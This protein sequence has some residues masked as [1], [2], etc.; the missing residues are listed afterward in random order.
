MK[1]SITKEN[2][3]WLM[4]VHQIP[5][6]PTSRR[7]RTWRRLQDIGAIA[8][9]NSVY[10][11]PDTKETFEDFQWLKQEIIST[12]GEAVIF[13]VDSIEGLT[14]QQLVEQFQEMRNKNYDKIAS[15]VLQLKSRAI[16][17]SENGVHEALRKKMSQELEKLKK[18][19]NETIS[20]DFFQASNKSKAEQAVIDCQ[21]LIENLQT[22]QN[23]ESKIKVY[24]IKEFQNKT[25]ITRKDIH[26]DRIAS[27]WV[28]KR[29]IDQEA[30]FRFINKNDPIKNGIGF[31]INN[32]M[33]SHVGENCTFE[34]L[35][36][37][38]DLID[39]AIQ[40]IAEIVHDIDLKDRKFLREEA[41]GLNLIII[42][43]GRILNDDYK[44]LEQGLLIFDGLY[45]FYKSQK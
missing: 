11:L 24:P 37:S 40:E 30:Q 3:K 12:S 35:T 33:F 45:Q 36:K 29:F 14:N 9:K 4:L 20:R 28:I 27:I 19:I 18:E 44:L 26:I 1:K 39:L 34:T 21:M 31:D 38:F 25:W 17:A 32:G 7:V 13:K 23:A 42:S 43:L 16:I 2:N 6:K 15:S 10:I 41:Q 22:R 5:A 8:L